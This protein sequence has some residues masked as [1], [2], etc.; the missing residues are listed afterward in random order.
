[1]VKSQVNYTTG[2]EDVSGKAG[3]KIQDIC[4]FPDPDLYRGEQA[5]KILSK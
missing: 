3:G 4:P 1:M 2:M 5:G